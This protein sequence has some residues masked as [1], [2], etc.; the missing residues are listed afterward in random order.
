[1]N[2]RVWGR[3][4]GPHL[5]VSR[6]QIGR[7]TVG[8]LPVSS[9]RP[10][11]PVALNVSIPDAIS[12]FVTFAPTIKVESE[13]WIL[14]EGVV[15][16]RADYA[17]ERARA[18]D[19]AMVVAALSAGSKE[20]AYR[21]QVVSADDG[22]TGQTLS[23]TSSS[24]E[25]LRA[26]LTAAELVTAR[27][28][29]ALMEDREDLAVAARQFDRG[30]RLSDLTAGELTTSAAI[31]AFFQVLEACSRLVPWSRPDDYDDQRAA[32]LATLRNELDAKALIK[33]KAGAVDKASNALARLDAKYMSLR[34]EHG[35]KELGLDQHWIERER[36][37]GRFRNSRLGHASNPATLL[38]MAEWARLD[39][40]E[41][42]IAHGLASTMLA[43]AFG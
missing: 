34:I 23:A 39:L 35:A 28:R 32:I 33:K 10:P 25:F 20:A 17:M 38:Q 18:E 3:I 7:A 40:A 9:Y 26:E 6:V 27:S 36:E 42:L 22:T 11:E 8:P 41:P 15:A 14:V 16:S 12:S 5:P 1:M 31:L 19:I 30:L 2:W 21:V 13:C 4:T 37:L 24:T 29:M 43:A